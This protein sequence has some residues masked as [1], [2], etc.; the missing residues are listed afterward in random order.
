MTRVMIADAHPS[1]RLGVRAL[2]STQAAIT[3]VGEAGDGHEAVRL[4]RELQPDLVIL[5]PL[6]PALSGL[7]ATRQLATVHPKVRVIVL[8]AQQ[9]ALFARALLG[10]G[11]S[12]YLSK[13]SPTTALMEAVQLVT[14]GKTYVDPAV[15][16]QRTTRATLGAES[17][18]RLPRL[19]ER[20][21]E[22]MRLFAQGLPTKEV[23]PK[24]SLSPRTVE[25]Y[26]ARAMLK[27]NLRSRAEFLKFALRCGW[28][29]EL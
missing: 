18:L 16:P 24:L 5:D 25:T 21:E 6:L 26:K 2:L 17:E 7:A 10:A 19:S 4:T 3:V 23:S 29:D 8:S 13:T 1:V 9:E 22:V 28:L 11:A 20:E 15:L 27:L 14:A 12:A